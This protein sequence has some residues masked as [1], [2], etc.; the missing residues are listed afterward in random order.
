MKTAL[1]FG[2]T[3]LIGSEL[4]RKIVDDAHYHDVKL[5]VRR[6]LRVRNLHAEVIQ[7]DFENLDDYAEL[8]KGDDCFCS[9]GTT[10]R[11]AR[12][13]EN[14][15][16]VDFDLVLKIAQ[17]AS[18]NGVKQFIVVSSVGASASSS[19][20][21]LRTKGE[22][23]EAIQKLPFEKVIIIRPSILVGRRKEFRLGERAGILFARL[24]IPFMPGPLKKYR[25]IHV[26]KV[27][28]ALLR[29]TNM[30]NAKTIY[31]SDELKKLGRV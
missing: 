26:K 12:S 7:V 25:P 30:R 6:N 1:L 8:I 17:T 20:F 3:G 11:K 10:I 2:A 19:N 27:V 15:R 29:I 9:I 16:K 4:L 22:M 18:Q 5:F 14:F 21:Y 31:E 24:M 13:K 23:E 28:K